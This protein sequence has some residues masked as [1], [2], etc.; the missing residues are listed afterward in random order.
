MENTALLSGTQMVLS[1]I[2][3]LSRSVTYK[4]V[5]STSNAYENRQFTTSV[6]TF[7]D[8]AICLLLAYNS[9]LVTAKRSW[10]YSRLFYTTK[11]C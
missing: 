1:S 6:H 4:M 7:Q 3:A 2:L 5:N 11:N 8:L 9:Y 10:P